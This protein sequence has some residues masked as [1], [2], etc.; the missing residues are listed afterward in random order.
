MSKALS[1]IDEL[2]GLIEKHSE[3]DLAVR[4]FLDTGYIPLN[5]MLSGKPDGGFAE[6]RIHEISGMQSCGKT[7]IATYAMK[8]A[9]A[10]GGAALFADHER[11]FDLAQAR[12]LG[13]QENSGRFIYNKPDTLE[14]SFTQA[15]RTGVKLR[16]KELIPETAPFVVVFDSV[17]AM[18]PASIYDKL[19]GGGDEDETMEDLNMRDQLALAA[20][21]SATLPAVANLAEKHNITIIFLNQ[22]RENPAPGPGDNTKTKGG[23]SL[24]FFASTRLKLSA[25]KLTK[26]VN[27]KFVQIGQKVTASS[28]KNKIVRPFLACE[29]D[30][31]FDENGRG[32]F[33]VIGGH[34]DYAKTRGT[35]ESSGNYLIW[36]GKKYYKSQLKELIVEKGLK[37]EL[38]KLCLA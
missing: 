5:T 6:G 18:I 13:L 31:M 1:L 16:D 34:I 15:L 32:H 28:I 19:T 29:W 25:A 11:S 3:E 33:D 27:G 14:R 9:I 38:D 17:A 8:S 24:P 4:S 20:A 37:P 22:L 2:D 30:F 7:A 10:A 12:H 35:L 36:D 23:K 21:M 26:Q